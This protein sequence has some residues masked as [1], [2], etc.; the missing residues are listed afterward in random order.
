M[1]AAPPWGFDLGCPIVG[2]Y[3]EN[4]MISP[5]L[6]TDYSVESGAIE[7]EFN[8]CLG[9]VHFATASDAAE[10]LA[11]TSNGSFDFQDDDG[12]H[13]HVL[14]GD[15]YV[16]QMELC[17]LREPIEVVRAP[18]VDETPAEII[19]EATSATYPVENECHDAMQVGH[20]H[21]GLTPNSLVP[22]D[23]TQTRLEDANR[24]QESVRTA[25]RLDEFPDNDLRSPSGTTLPQD[26][27][28]DVTCADRVHVS[29]SLPVEVV[30]FAPGTEDIP[31]DEHPE[32]ETV[33]SITTQ[34][35]QAVHASTSRPMTRS[36]KVL[37]EG[38]FR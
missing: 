34:E 22:F 27:G 1:A 6:L 31:T 3:V 9:E 18:S 8:D 32:A 23:E 11:L 16:D 15:G 10:I 36:R 37:D 4:G 35:K 12:R 38:V 24:T 2:L 33:I 25:V 19:E 28:R 30:S 17:E 21:P 26:N 29:S 14:V 20:V 7:P 13:D 5:Q